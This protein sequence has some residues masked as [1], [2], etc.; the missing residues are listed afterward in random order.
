MLL[1]SYMD[2]LSP[3]DQWRV[4]LVVNCGIE[5]VFYARDRLERLIPRMRVARVLTETE[6]AEIESDPKHSSL[7]FGSHSTPSRRRFHSAC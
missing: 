1:L 3:H 7:D 4:G 5:Q 2:G 6:V